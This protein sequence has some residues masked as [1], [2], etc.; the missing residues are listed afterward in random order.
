MG[1][2]NLT[3]M[4]LYLLLLSRTIH[5]IHGYRL[6][7][8][9]YVGDR[10]KHASS[11]VSYDDQHR[12]RSVLWPKICVTILEEYDHHEPSQSSSHPVVRR[13]TTRKCFH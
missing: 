9:E 11:I 3:C 1:L 7:H 2:L 4:L 8:L 13:R 12:R 6:R 10:V 5:E